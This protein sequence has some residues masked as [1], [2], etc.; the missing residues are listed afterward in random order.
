M[1][2]VSINL[3]DE[4]YAV[5]AAW[6]GTRKGSVRT[7]SA[8]RT[9]SHRIENLQMVQVGDR[10]TSADGKFELMWTD[11]GWILDPGFEYARMSQGDVDE[12]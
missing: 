5:Y 9:Y 8:V 3:S 12:S 1:P 4:A 11:D 6:K 10:R 2:I 7:S